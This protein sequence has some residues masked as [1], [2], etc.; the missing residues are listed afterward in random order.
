VNDQSLPAGYAQLCRTYRIW[1]IVPRNHFIALG[2]DDND[3]LKH[4]D[5]LP[6]TLRNA[7]DHTVTTETIIEYVVA[8]YGREKLPLFIEAMGNHT[9]AATLI[10]AVFDLSVA[11]FEAGWQAYMTEQ[12]GVK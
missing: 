8:A 5:K 6:L 10:P 2:C 7:F 1:Q 11:E 9:W 4:L 3:E 12:Y